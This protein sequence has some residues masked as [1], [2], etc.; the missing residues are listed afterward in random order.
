MKYLYLLAFLWSSSV[1]LAAEKTA[2]FYFVDIGHGNVTFV[3]SPSGETMLLDC[4][5][6]RAVD[7]IY[8]FM[9][10]NGIKKIDYLFVTHFEDDHMGAAPALA[11][12]VPIINCVDHGESVTYGKTDDWWLCRRQPWFRVGMAMADDA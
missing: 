10:Q 7:R 12:K 9:Q 4:G 1:A 8:D 11:E 2:Q 6:T 5:P 3:I